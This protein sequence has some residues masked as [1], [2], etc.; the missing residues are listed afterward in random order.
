VID[1]KSYEKR[2]RARKSELE[3]RLQ[4]IEH[5]LDQPMPADD[6]DRATER[7]GDEL[8]EQVGNAGAEELRAIDAALARIESG[9]YG[10]CTNCGE[11]ISPERL[12]TL[13]Y[14]TRCRHCM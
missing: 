11:E 1:T 2:L 9:T 5:D 14:A 3:N 8:L 6:E 4:R 10:V 7:Q 12:E 13:P